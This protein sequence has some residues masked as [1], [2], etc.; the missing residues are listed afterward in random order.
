MESQLGGKGKKPV[1]LLETEEASGSTKRYNYSNPVPYTSSNEL[2]G[3]G[4]LA[5]VNFRPAIFN[6]CAPT[7]WC[8]MVPGCAMGI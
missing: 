3:T 6:H 1:N 7:H 8:A 2:S 5:S 4:S